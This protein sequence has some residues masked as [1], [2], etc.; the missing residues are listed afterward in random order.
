MQP[1]DAASSKLPDEESAQEPMPAPVDL[2]E[3]LRFYRVWISACPACPD[4]SS[5]CKFQPAI[6]GWCLREAA[7]AFP[8]HFLCI[9][10]RRSV[11]SCAG[12]DP[13]LGVQAVML[14]S[15]GLPLVAG[16]N[17]FI[18]A[19]CPVAFLAQ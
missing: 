1:P 17:L 5:C 16:G 4:G 14:T 15:A 7:P 9:P 19:F 8:P 12:G 11:M 6:T 13:V 2:H 10:V 3:W 18:T